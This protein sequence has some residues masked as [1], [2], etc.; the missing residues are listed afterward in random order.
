MPT[1]PRLSH[2]HLR[3]R[4]LERAVAFY[5]DVFGWHAT[6]RLGSDFVFLSGGSAHHE[7]ALQSAPG[8]Q[9]EG[10][11]GVLY[12]VALEV[13]SARE[14][15]EV[16]QRLDM[17]GMPVSAV[18]HGISWALYF[19]DPDGNGMECFLDRRGARDGRSEWQGTSARLTRGMVMEEANKP[20]Q[21]V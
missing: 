13:N 12:H 10:D 9:S 14:L 17:R 16:W 21:A 15:A 5:Q 7:V 3:V 2:V 1:L 20:P 19:R 18:D 6:E 8:L 4:S 11:E